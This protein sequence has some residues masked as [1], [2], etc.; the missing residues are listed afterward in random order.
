MSNKDKNFHVNN[1]FNN[2]KNLKTF[3]FRDA[4][5]NHLKNYN[6]DRN[7][8]AIF[9]ERMQFPKNIEKEFRFDKPTKYWSGINT[10]L[11][12][13]DFLGRVTVFE[14]FKFFLKVAKDNVK[15][16]KKFDETNFEI[17][18][19]NKNELF[20]LYQI[21]LLHLVGEL[22]SSKEFRLNAGIKDKQISKKVNLFRYIKL[23]L[24]TGRRFGA[25]TRFKKE[26]FS[27]SEARQEVDTLYPPISD[28]YLFERNLIKLDI[29]WI[30]LV[31]LISISWYLNS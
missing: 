1:F 23:W 31:L 30:V 18:Q 28:D 9:Y 25:F 7:A 21:T 8:K 20:S 6:Q 14:A 16:F 13:P 2:W 29:S 10:A 12:D 5:I 3:P 24:R 19:K 22:Y 15:Y 27:D 17:N 26:N 11:E 4:L